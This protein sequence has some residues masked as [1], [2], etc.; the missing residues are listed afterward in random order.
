MKV[1]ALIIE[2]GIKNLNQIKKE[3]TF[4][5]IDIVYG[6]SF[7][8]VVDT[9]HLEKVHI[10]ALSDFR[11]EKSSIGY[12]KMFTTTN[13][14]FKIIFLSNN[15]IVSEDTR[16]FFIERGAED[17]ISCYNV[18][19][20]KKCFNKIYLRLVSDKQIDNDWSNCTKRAIRYLKDNYQNKKVIKNISGLVNYSPSTIYHYVKKD[21]GITV[22]AWLQKLRINGAIELLQST[23]IPIKKISQK[24]GYG[25]VQGFIKIFKKQTNKLPSDFRIH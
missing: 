14:D 20:I 19:E 25:S 22:G 21:T 12:L 13:P 9:I 3:L 24:L 1:K 4:K 15:K 17:F 2:I 6:S 7:L 5:N 16:C 23:H 10:I 11:G 18:D 8:D